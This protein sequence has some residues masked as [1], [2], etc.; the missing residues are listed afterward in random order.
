MSHIV[1]LT[2]VLELTK[3]N[4]KLI[5]EKM[6]AT[7]EYHP[8]D[9]NILTGLKPDDQLKVMETI[10]AHSFSDLFA[11]ACLDRGISVASEVLQSSST[12]GIAGAA[13]LI[14]VKIHDILMTSGA[15]MDIV[16]EVSP[17]VSCP[18]SSLKVDVE[19]D[20]QFKVRAGA[21][22]GQ[23]PDETM[24]TTQVTITPELW[25]IK[26]RI[27]NDL[28]EDSQFD[29]LEYHLRRAAEQMGEYSTLNWL[30]RAIAASGG[31]GTQNTVTTG[32]AN[33][34]YIADIY[35]CWNENYQDKFVSDCVVCGPEP[36][37]DIKADT[38]VG[39]YANEY[40]NRAV[41]DPVLQTGSI[42]GMRIFAVPMSEVYTGDGAL[43]LGSKWHSLVFNKANF[44]M[45][46]RK[47]W[48]KL[49]KFSDPVRD[50]VGAVLTSRQASATLY[51]D[52][53][54]ET[55]ES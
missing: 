21:S 4:R 23:M 11:K 53:S 48:M 55:T 14:P 2:E 43:Y 51:N 24:Q 28:I 26:P 15:I 16:P 7:K 31:D 27:A 41:T 54:C 37:V 38:G 42:G 19:V 50:L 5:M 40:K 52:A 46:V 6:E 8:T 29:V 18:G 17:I 10:R 39:A 22:G 34:T 13:Y 44:T 30:K 33:K 9:A 45:T 47:R 1:G 32:T 25:T 3:D 35:E 20:G 36:A 49:E 12:T